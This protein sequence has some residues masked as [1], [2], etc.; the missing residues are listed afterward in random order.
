MWQY[1]QLYKT[2]VQP[3]R[4]W[5]L[6]QNRT[7]DAITQVNMN[8]SGKLFVNIIILLKVEYKF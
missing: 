8:T 2:R 5:K 7:S 4:G 1:G 3:T 6:K